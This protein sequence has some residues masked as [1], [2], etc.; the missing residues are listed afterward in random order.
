MEN[1]A[2]VIPLKPEKIR[3]L[4]STGNLKKCPDAIKYYNKQQIQLLRR[5]VKDAAALAVSKGNFTAVKEWLAIDV[6]TSTGLRVSEL[7]N[8]RCGD[9]STG[10]GSTP[11]IYIRDGKGHKPRTV[12]IPESLK[13]HL[14]Q[15]L[16]WKRERGERVGEDDY[17][18][19]GQ[20][21][22]W[23][24]QAVQ[25]L[26]KKYLKM[27]DLYED[28]KSVHALRHSYAVQLYR[29]E[30]D[31]RAV[32]KQLGHSS[33]KTSQIYADVLEEDLGRQ[34]RGMWQI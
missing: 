28:G 21:G 32:Q 11:S 5:T 8:L 29:R 15:F 4:R 2:K 20:R 34:V 30:R 10:Y 27:L 6:L 17:L 9:L 1:T 31:L 23:T 7:A 3:P 33:I 26:V 25:Q 12:I 22:P 14:K 13:K 16:V 24:R 18:F 19:C